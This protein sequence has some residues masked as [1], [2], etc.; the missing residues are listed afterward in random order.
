MPDSTTRCA[1]KAWKIEEHQFCLNCHAV[2]I[3][4]SDDSHFDTYF[5]YFYEANKDPP[6]EAINREVCGCN[7]TKEYYNSDCCWMTSYYLFP[8]H[9]KEHL[10]PVSTIKQ[11]GSAE[12][13]KEVTMNTSDA[14][15]NLVELSSISNIGRFQCKLNE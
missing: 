6:V 12:S 5:K 11:E 13:C 9:M 14:L 3:M 8:E 2:N 4:R 1:I 10:T 7:L 15:T